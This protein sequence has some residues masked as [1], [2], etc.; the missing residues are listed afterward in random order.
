M[1]KVMI[2]LAA[3]FVLALSGGA[4]FLLMQP[5]PDYVPQSPAAVR[6]DG[7]EIGGPFTLTAHTGERVTAET[8]IDGP[9]LIYFGYTFCPDICPIDTQTMVDAVVLLED[10][11]IAVDPVFVTVDPARDTPEVLG[12]W[13]DIMHPRMVGLTGSEAE[14]RAAADA[15]KVYYQRQEVPG[16]AAEYLY[17][18][19]GFT[20]FM[21]PDGIAGLFRN[22]FPPEEIA[23][24]IERILTARGRTS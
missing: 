5:A 16:S 2:G 4:V 10:R 11:G 9:T 24:E 1:R 12:E 18:H 7:S 14:I 13:S 8:L 23:D 21:M 19:T 6:V 22:G 3:G 17:S 20:Y 15:Y